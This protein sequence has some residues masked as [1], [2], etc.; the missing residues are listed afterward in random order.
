LGS[1]TFPFC[2]FKRHSKQQFIASTQPMPI[3]AKKSTTPVLDHSTGGLAKQLKEA[4]G[5]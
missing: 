1:L 5:D 2:T 3:Q 4:D